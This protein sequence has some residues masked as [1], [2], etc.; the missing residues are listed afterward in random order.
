MGRFN[1]CYGSNDTQEEVF[2]NE[3]E[4]LI[5]SPSVIEIVISGDNPTGGISYD[6][7]GLGGGAVQKQECNSGGVI[8]PGFGHIAELTKWD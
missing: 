5:R 4:G 1:S 2:V 3:V 8:I 6:M 7:D